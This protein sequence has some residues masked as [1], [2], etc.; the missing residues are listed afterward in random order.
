MRQDSLEQEGKDGREEKGKGK[1]KDDQNK[2]R[3][4]AMNASVHEYINE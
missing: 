1:A 2:G 4:V 3:I